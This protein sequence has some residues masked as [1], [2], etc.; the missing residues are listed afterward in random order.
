M[1]AAPPLV[2]H[3]SC[4]AVEGRGLLIL[5]PSGA[6]KS[7]LALQMIAL[8]AQLV[9][10]DR[11]EITLRDGRLVARCPQ[12][13]SGLI[14]ARGVGILHSP[15]IAEATLQ[16]AVDLGAAETARLPE[17]HSIVFLGAQLDLVHVPSNT[18]FP[19]SLVVYLRG[20]R[21]A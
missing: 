8:G 21:A 3:A 14:E 5:G 2:L 16:L 9:A 7:A 19:A 18:H 1:T 10:D 6:G 15:P 11:V 20:G 12:A 4:V 17:Q 13:I